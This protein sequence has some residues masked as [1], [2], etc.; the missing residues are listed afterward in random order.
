MA[1]QITQDDRQRPYNGQFYSRNE[2]YGCKSKGHED[3]N[4]WMDEVHVKRASGQIL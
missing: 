2:G 4:G 3:E 1:R